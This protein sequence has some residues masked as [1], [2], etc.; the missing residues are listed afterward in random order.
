MLDHCRQDGLRPRRRAAIF[1][2][3]QRQGATGV[4]PQRRASS[5]KSRPV[6][7]PSATIQEGG[8]APVVQEHQGA[9]N[10]RADFDGRVARV[11]ATGSPDRAIVPGS[12]GL[13]PQ[14]DS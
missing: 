4:E 13:D 2:P 5:G 10:V 8:R 11:S 1:H 3:A 14:G 12:N 9:M 7:D 6:F